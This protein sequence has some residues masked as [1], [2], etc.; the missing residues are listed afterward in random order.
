M[1]EDIISKIGSIV[2]NIDFII[3]MLKGEFPY[4]TFGDNT[5]REFMKCYE[6]LPDDIA[7][8]LRKIDSEFGS[9]KL[10]QLK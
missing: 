6:D 9:L 7:E 1:K 10:T 5:V 4:L 2:T 3:A 8:Q